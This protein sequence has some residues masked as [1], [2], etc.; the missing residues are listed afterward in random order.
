MLDFF[1]VRLLGDAEEVFFFGLLAVAEV[2]EDADAVGNACTVA[3]S[4]DVAE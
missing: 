4:G 2:D 3:L 1:F